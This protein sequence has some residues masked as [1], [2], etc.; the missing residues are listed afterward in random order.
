MKNIPEDIVSSSAQYV[1]KHLSFKPDI[2]VVLGSGLSSIKLGCK[3]EIE[4][5]GIPN[6]PKPSVS[7]HFGK[8]YFNS[9]DNPKLLIIAGR[10]HLYEKG[11]LTDTLYPIRVLH[12][13]GCKTVVLTNAAGGVNTHYQAGDLMLIDDHINLT[14]R[15]KELLAAK[16]V[17]DLQARPANP[18]YDLELLRRAQELAAKA[19]VTVQRGIYCG[20]LGPSYETA[21]EIR[22]MRGFGADA[23]GMSTVNEAELA[24]S[25][26][27]RVMGISYISNLATGLS[28]SPLTHKEV[29]ENSKKI[30]ESLSRLLREI[31]LHYNN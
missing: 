18:I 14:Y 13:L 4:N 24:A 8:M 28:P 20:L 30:E 6:Y 19:G 12:S 31:V 22:M 15:R 17:S 9:T 27:M 10:T 21:A 2:A 16:S 7:G 25:F 23:V 1:S 11:N 29:L 26:G 5:D 3:S